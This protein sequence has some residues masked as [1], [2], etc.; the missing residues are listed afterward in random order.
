MSGQASQATEA[1][2]GQRTVLSFESADADRAATTGRARFSGA[3]SQSLCLVGGELV[4]V[5]RPSLGAGPFHGR[6]SGRGAVG[7]RGLQPR[8]LAPLARN[9]AG[10][11]DSR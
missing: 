4:V 1:A 7:R 8:P 9:V 11:R 5:R 3:G 10:C 2:T 6:I